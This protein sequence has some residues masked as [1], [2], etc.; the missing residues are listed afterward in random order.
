MVVVPL[1][2]WRF[3]YEVCTYAR[4]RLLIQ[5]YSTSM[6]RQAAANGR[7]SERARL[8]RGR[9]RRGRRG[10][11]LGGVEARPGRTGRVDVRPVEVP[12]GDLEARAE[13][14]GHARREQRNGRRG[15]HAE[16]EHGPHAGVRPPNGPPL[17]LSRLRNLS[18]PVALTSCITWLT[19]LMGAH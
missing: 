11:R 1:V 14:L 16:E 3:S 12:G 7:T 18:W 17:A 9:W 5:S 4:A 2:F 8:P 15:Q 10:R 19:W 6:V 13:L